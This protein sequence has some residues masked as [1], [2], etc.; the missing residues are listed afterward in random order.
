MIGIRIMNQQ[1]LEQKRKKQ[2]E[3]AL[4]QQSI[5]QAFGVNNP[6]LLSNEANPTDEVEVYGEEKFTRKEVKLPAIPTS[7]SRESMRTQSVTEKQTQTPKRIGGK[8]SYIQIPPRELFR[9]YD[10]VSADNHRDVRTQASVHQE[11]VPG[12]FTV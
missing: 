1:K 12:W 2:L 11:D 9:N 8:D 6:G 5:S 7:K 3:E 10:A 4:Y